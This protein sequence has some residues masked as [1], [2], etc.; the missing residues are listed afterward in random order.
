M[1]YKLRKAPNRDLYWVVSVETGAKH[2]KEPI[3]KAKAEA[4]MRI[5]VSAMRKHPEA[6]RGGM[7]SNYIPP[8]PSVVDAVEAARK[9]NKTQL[10]DDEFLRMWEGRRAA[11]ELPTPEYANEFLIQ[12]RSHTNAQDHRNAQGQRV[13]DAIPYNWRLNRPRML[14]LL[15]YYFPPRG[16]AKGAVAAAQPPPPPPPKKNQ[17]NDHYSH[18]IPAL[19]QKGKRNIRAL[20]GRVP[21]PEVTELQQM[22]EQLNRELPPNILGL[23]REI[24]IDND[25]RIRLIQERLS[26]RIEMAREERIQQTRAPVDWSGYETP[27]DL[28]P[29]DDYHSYAPT[30]TS[31]DGT[32]RSLPLTPNNEGAGRIRGGHYY[33]SGKDTRKARERVD[34][35]NT[36]S[37]V[38][39]NEINDLHNVVKFIRNSLQNT[40]NTMIDEV[41]AQDQDIITEIQELMS[42]PATFSNP[43]TNPEWLEYWMDINIL[44]DELEHED[45][46]DSVDMEEGVEGRGRGGS[47]MDV[48]NPDKVMNEIFNPKSV[49]RSR[50]SDVFKGI[51]TS[52]PPSARKFL[53]ANGN[54][55]IQSITIRR[56]PI[57]SALNTAFNLITLGKWNKER[58]NENYDKLFH[59][60]LVLTLSNGKTV[61]VEKNE[62][63]NIGS[64]IPVT[65]NTETMSLSRL[66]THT[67]LDEFIANGV[68][69]KGADFYKYDPFNNNCQDFVALLLKANHNYPAKAATFVKQPVDNLVKRLPQWTQPIA[70]G[71]TDLG[72][73]ANVAVEGA[74]RSKF[75]DQLNRI[76]LKPS[77]YL[78][79]ARKVAKKAGYGDA[80]KLL[81]FATDGK[82]KLAIANQEGK[83]VSFGLA[84]YGDSLIWSHL[85]HLKKVPKGSAMM[86]RRNYHARAEKARGNWKADPFSP[87]NLA[88]KIL[89]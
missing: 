39:T 57:P 10:T 72:A 44:L 62:V 27:S 84:G 12:L 64:P 24:A 9:G 13:A 17:L 16:G 73:I 21:I 89:W 42:R 65:K 85:E 32:V 35:T 75:S 8:M 60:S 1:P 66:P 33:L 88:L 87:N 46:D 63:I 51:R 18:L 45:D 7:N 19:T 52:L 20:I 36:G 71:I 29:D 50:V 15:N 23:R 37:A 81:G 5:L 68:K 48:F 74:G 67:T 22:R 34:A 40:V 31:R 2:S 4:Q 70:K 41:D 11:G 58:L 78:E 54:A 59:L 30:A 56:D 14:S 53:E 82:H 38:I 6:H 61:L 26:R 80:A 77:V 86:K 43:P 47:F 76:G 28:E 69:A 49:V 25:P 79:N 55:Q 3:P 83:I